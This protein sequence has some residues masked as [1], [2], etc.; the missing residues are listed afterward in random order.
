MLVFLFSALA[1]RAVGKAAQSIIEEV[2][3][4]YSKLPREND[5]IQFPEDFKPDY[6]SCV[7]IVT[8]SALKKMVLPGILPVLTPLVVGILFKI[9]ITENDKLISA[10]SVAS[11]LMVGTITGILMALF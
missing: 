8:K 5:I 1:I 3:R 2:R 10:E 11:L 9:F 4:Q 6:G 7:D